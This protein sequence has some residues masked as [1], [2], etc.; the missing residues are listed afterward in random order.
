M[1]SSVSHAAPP[2]PPPPDSYGPPPPFAAAEAA[3]P[4]KPHEEEVAEP[5]V[6]YLNLPCPVPYEEIQREAFSKSLTPSPFHRPRLICAF[7]S[8]RSWMAYND[9]I[10]VACVA[11]ALKPDLFEGMRF[12]F[13]KMISPYFALSHRCSTR[14]LSLFFLSCEPLAV[15]RC[16]HNCLAV[17]L[18]E[19][20]WPWDPLMSRHRGTR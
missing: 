12:D 7:D 3:A 17:R 14:C 2:P 9:V 13:T 4:P 1:G 8:R 10:F 5:K 6:D 15:W 11:V 19:P 20:V 18:F 16:C